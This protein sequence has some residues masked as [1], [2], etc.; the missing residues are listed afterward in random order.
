LNAGLHVDTRAGGSHQEDEIRQGYSSHG[1]PIK[2]PCSGNVGTGI[3]KMR[4]FDDMVLH[5]IGDI[6]QQVESRYL[7]HHHQRDRGQGQAHLLDCMRYILSG[8][9]PETAWAIRGPEMRRGGE[10]EAIN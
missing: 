8:F 5:T 6:G 3:D 4:I 10:G 7:R 9:A 2:E 1:Q